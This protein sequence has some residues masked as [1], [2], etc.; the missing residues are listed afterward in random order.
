MALLCT[1]IFG[2]ACFLIMNISLVMIS[3]LIGVVSVA[4][5]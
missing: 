1:T 5:N 3:N 4:T 2:N